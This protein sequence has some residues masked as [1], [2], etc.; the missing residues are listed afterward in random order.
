MPVTDDKKV[1]GMT[2]LA[3]NVAA[4]NFWLPTVGTTTLMTIG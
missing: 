4:V 1:I 3:N 2:V